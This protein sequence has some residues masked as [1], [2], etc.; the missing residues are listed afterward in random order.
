[1]PLSGPGPSGPLTGTAPDRATLRRRLR[2]ISQQKLVDA[3][4]DELEQDAL[5][6]VV[7]R[8]SK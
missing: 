4:L 7:E 3:L 5:R 6:R 2:A 8:A 1:M